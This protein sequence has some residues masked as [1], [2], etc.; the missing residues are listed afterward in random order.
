MFFDDSTLSTD[1]FVISPDSSG[2]SDFVVFMICA[3]EEEAEA[4]MDEVV[5]ILGSEF[6]QDERRVFAHVSGL[7]EDITRSLEDM[8]F[9]WQ[10]QD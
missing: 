10:E 2:E 4:L 1:L 5:P 6:Q 3:D 9:D 8:G 7:F